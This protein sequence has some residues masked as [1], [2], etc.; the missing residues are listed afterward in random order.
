MFYLCILPEQNAI[1]LKV[2]GKR[3]FSNY[4]ES[5]RFNNSLVNDAWV[6]EEITKEIKKFSGLK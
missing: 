1:K 4:M 3:T 6:K 2:K 5:K